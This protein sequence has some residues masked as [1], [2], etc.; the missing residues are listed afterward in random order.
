MHIAETATNTVVNT[1]PTAAS[2]SS[3]LNGMAVLNACE[4]IA[5]R[6]EPYKAANPSGTFADWVSAAYFDRV[7]LSANGFYKVL[8]YDLI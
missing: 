7:N 3:D 4:Q 6:L 5:A 8:F 1:T 2:A